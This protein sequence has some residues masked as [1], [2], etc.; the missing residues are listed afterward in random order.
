LPDKCAPSALAQLVVKQGP[1][2]HPALTPSE[3]LLA[4]RTLENWQR[5]YLADS[6]TGMSERY[7][8][9]HGLPS[10]MRASLRRIAELARRNPR[11]RDEGGLPRLDGILVPAGDWKAVLGGIVVHTLKGWDGYVLVF[12]EGQLDTRRAVRLDLPTTVRLVAR[13]DATITRTLRTP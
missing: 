9:A 5:N 8:R 6:F 3:G 4:F 12:V 2:A 13:Y 11:G 1:A 7:K 10:R